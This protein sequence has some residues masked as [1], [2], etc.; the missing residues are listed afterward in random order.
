M[1]PTCKVLPDESTTSPAVGNIHRDNFDCSAS[2][3]LFELGLLTDEFPVETSW[4]HNN[5]ASV[6]F[7]TGGPYDKPF[8]GY[9]ISGCIPNG[10]CALVLHDTYGDGLGDTT[11]S[12]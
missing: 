5:Y 1:N 7:M 9:K 8:F 10:E 2:Q 3:V 12:R 4:K 6:L 11:G